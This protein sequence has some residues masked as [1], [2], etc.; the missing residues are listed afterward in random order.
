[1]DIRIRLGQVGGPLVVL[2]L[3]D[4]VNCADNDISD[5]GDTQLYDADEILSFDIATKTLSFSTISDASLIGSRTY[6][7]DIYL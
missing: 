3:M 7:L 4:L 2:Q 5:N 1:M 6:T